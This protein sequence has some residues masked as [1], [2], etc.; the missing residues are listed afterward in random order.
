MTARFELK[1]LLASNTNVDLD[2]SMKTK[3]ALKRLGYYRA[4]RYGMTPYPDEQLFSGISDLQR[5][6]GLRRTGEMRPGDD[7]EKA[8]RLALKDK[9]SSGSENADKEGKYIWRTRGDGKVRS[10]HAE[11]DGKVFDWNDPPEGG[12]P[13]EAPNCRC[14]AEVIRDTGE[15]C[16]K[17]RID[18]QRQ[19]IEVES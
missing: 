1:S 7:T 11:R 6:K 3:T 18:I 16:N 15:M 12:H 14:T 17:L 5:D 19:T 10:E 13:G 2:D 8:I 4:P 9:P